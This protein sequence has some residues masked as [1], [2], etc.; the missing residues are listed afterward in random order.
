M[1]DGATTLVNF[2]SDDCKPLFLKHA[3][4]E[5][6]MP[7]TTKDYNGQTFSLPRPPCR[8]DCEDF[9]DT[10]YVSLIEAEPVLHSVAQLRRY[11]SDLYDTWCDMMVDGRCSPDDEVGNCDFEQFNVNSPIRYVDLF[12]S[13]ASFPKEGLSLPDGSKIACSSNDNEYVAPPLECPDGFTEFYGPATGYDSIESNCVFPCL[14]FLFTP[15]Q[16][17]LQFGV[18]AGMGFFAVM[19]N[20]ILVV[21]YAAAGKKARKSGSVLPGFVVQCAVLGDPIDYIPSVIFHRLDSIRYN[22]SYS[23]D[24][25]PSVITHYNPSVILLHRSYSI[26]YIPSYSIRCIPSI[27]FHPLYSIGHVPSVIFHRSYFIRYIPSYFIRYNPSFIYFIRYIP[28]YYIRYIPS[29][30]FHPLYFIGH[31]SSV[32][33]HRSCFVR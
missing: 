20:L 5:I 31:I 30:R 16:I 10:C 22:P 28:S 6:I 14:S 19:T 24:Y 2:V 11:S 13:Q 1:I 7:C 18:Y 25:I 26:H 29:I 33:F 15:E 8:S 23:I 21:S 12:Q 17:D 9:I 27:I 32:I 3:C 4:S